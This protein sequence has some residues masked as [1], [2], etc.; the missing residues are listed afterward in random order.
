MKGT[1][2]LVIMCALTGCAMQPSSLDRDLAEYQET[3]RRNLYADTAT[4]CRRAGGY[5]II[6]TTGRLPR[7]GMPRSG[8]E[9]S[10]M[11]PT[12]SQ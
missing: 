6:R 10:C 3:D 7:N 8:D 11:P 5:M 9:Y 4:L 1:A 12:L 2:L